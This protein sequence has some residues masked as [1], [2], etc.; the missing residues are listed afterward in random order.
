VSALPDRSRA[1]VATEPCATEQRDLPLPAVGHE[2]V[3]S[4]VALGERAAERW[5]VSVGHRVAVEEYLPCGAR[6]DPAAIHVS[7]MP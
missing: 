7:V 3:G 1:A 2:N 6:L 5:G 4:V